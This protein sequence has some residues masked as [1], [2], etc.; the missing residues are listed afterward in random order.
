MSALNKQK[1]ENKFSVNLVT[2][3]DMIERIRIVE[4]SEKIQPTRGA[5]DIVHMR[6]RKIS[7]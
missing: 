6:F 5:G 4:G 2:A 3:L 1:E 7:H